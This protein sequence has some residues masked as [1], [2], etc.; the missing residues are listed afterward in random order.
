MKAKGLFL[1]AMFMF[2][3]T[4]P[5]FGQINSDELS[6]I[7][8]KARLKF[9]L[10]AVAVVILNSKDIYITE[11][12]GKKFMERKTVFQLTIIFILVPVLS[13]YLQ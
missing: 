7:V 9:K 12:Q 10:P 1:I 5:S 4:Q 13:Q 8:E 11:I 6:K 3:K 2:L